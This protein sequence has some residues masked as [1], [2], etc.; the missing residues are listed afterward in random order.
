[1]CW[2]LSVLHKREQAIAKDMPK[3]KHE[4]GTEKINTASIKS[5]LN[6]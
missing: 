2:L 6:P 4:T 5:K 3:E 1:M